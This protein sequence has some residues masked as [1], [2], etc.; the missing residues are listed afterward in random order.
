MESNGGYLNCLRG[1]QWAYYNTAHQFIIWY[2][3][4]CTAHVDA[5]TLLT[6]ER[7]FADFVEF[8]FSEKLRVF[9]GPKR[10][11]ARCHWLFVFAIPDLIMIFAS[12]GWSLFMFMFG[13]E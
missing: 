4:V 12:R 7:R 6:G 1:R 9:A 2:C 8:S 11:K 13:K 5:H 10:L 3:D